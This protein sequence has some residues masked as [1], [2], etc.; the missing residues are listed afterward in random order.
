MKWVNKIRAGA[1]HG[2]GESRGTEQAMGR[3]W[4]RKLRRYPVWSVARMK[5][6][7]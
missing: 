3:L 5:K 2:R 6:V 1:F 7:E 4:M